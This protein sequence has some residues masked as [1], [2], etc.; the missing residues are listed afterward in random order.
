VSRSIGPA[1]RFSPFHESFLHHAAATPDLVALEFEGQTV[2][3][4]ELAA[5]SGRLATHLRGLGVGP[6]TLVGVAVDRSPELVVGILGI[7]RAGGAWLPLDPSYPAA[8]L[9]YMLDD[10]HVALVVADGVGA[11][12]L[13]GAGVQRVDPG[14]ASDGRADAPP[15]VSLSPDNL[16]YVIYTSGSTGR[17]KGVEVTHG[18]LA[19]LTEALVPYLGASAGK[20]VLQFFS[21]SFDA[22]VSEIVTAL[23]AGATLVLTRAVE[24]GPGFVEFLRSARIT[25]VSLPP[26]L[27]AVLP[28]ADLP[29]LET[30]VCGG[31]TLPEALA[32]RW[33][34]G[35]RLV[36]AY[37]PTEATVCT[38]LADVQPGGGKPPIGRP[39]AGAHVVVLDD[40]L[41]PLPP[42][43]AGQLAIGGL[44]VARGYRGSPALTAERFIP[45]W[46]GPTTGGRLYLTGDSGRLLP[47]G[48]LEFLGRNDDQVKLRGFRIELEEVAAA[49]REHPM[50]RD[51]AAAVRDDSG[52]DRLVAYATGSGLTPG[53]LRQHLADRLPS[54]MVPSAVVVLEEFPLL[55]SGKLDRQ[56]LPAPDRSSAELSVV[57]TAARTPTEREVARLV[58]ELLGVSEIG[59]DDDFFQLGGHSLLAGRLAARAR[60]DL[61]R[62]L[63]IARLYQAPT[64][65]GIA[66]LLDSLPEGRQP[67]PL[68]RTGRSGP[69]PLAFPQERIWF[70]EQLAP[71]NLAYNA[72][73]SVRLR[74]PLDRAVLE[75]TLTEIV[76]RH[77]IL[78]TRFWAVE[79]APVQEPVAP[80]AIDVPFVDVSDLPPAEGEAR[81]EETIRTSM[82]QPFDFGRPPL[83]RW[84][85]IRHAEHDHTLLQVEHH[86]VHDGWSWALF[87][88]ELQAIYGAFHRRQPSPLPELAVQ[89]GDFAV[90]QRNWL[91]DAVLDEYLR[92]WTK[93]LSGASYV[94]NLPT[95]RPRPAMQS[96]VGHALRIDLP[97]E[98]CRQ[99]REFSRSRGVTLYATMLAGFAA[100]LHRYT[101]QTDL[102][103]GCAAA[104][105][106]LAEVE[107]LIGMVV[108]T[109]VLRIDASARPGLDRLARRVHETTT[110]TYD[111]QDVPLDR[112]VNAL[113]LPHDNSRNPLFQ[114]AFSFHDSP[115]PAIEF[116]GLRGTIVE[117]HNG[118]AK[119]DLGIVVIPRAEQQVGVG[120]RDDAAAIT[121][122]WEYATDLFDESTM[123]RMVDHYQNLLGAALCQPEVAIDRLPMLG[124]DE[125]Q[126][127]TQANGVGP[128]AEVSSPP[129]TLPGL[130]EAQVA[131][132][133]EAAAIVFGETVLTYQQLD[134][135]AN[136]LAHA[137][138]ARGVGPEQTVGVA[139]SRSTD[140]VVSILAATKA[141]A[142][143]LPVDPDFP[144][145]RIEALVRDAKPAVLLTTSQIERRLPGLALDT[146]ILDDEATIRLLEG[147]PESPPTDAERITPLHPLHPAYVIY[148]SGSTGTRKGVVVP[149]AGIGS[150]VAA[151]AERFG[152]GAG[153]RVLQFAAPS[154]DA[155][156]AEVAVA[157][158]T[159]ATLVVAPKADIMP[160][161]DLYRL[162]LDKRVT[163][164][165]LPPS[166]LRALGSDVGLPAHLTLVVAGEAC[167]ADLVTQWSRGRR[168][169]NAYGPTET[170][171]CAT[172]SGPLRPGDA[173]PPIGRPIDDSRVYVLD[174]ALQVV[175]VG[176]PGELYVAGAGLARGYLGRPALTAERFVADPYGPPGA[177]MYRTGDVVRWN[178]DHQLEF[179]RRADDQVKIRGFR[180]EPGEI[181]AALATHP[182]V[183][184]VK[185]VV[186]QD[187][188]PDEKSLV[189]YVVSDGAGAVAARDLRDHLVQRLPEYMVPAAIVMLDAF[190]LTHNGKLD[191]DA[192]PAPT[193][194]SAP[195]RPPRT[196]HEQVLADL[197]CELLHLPQVGV[198]DSFFDLGGHS[199][200]AVRL[201][202]RIGA[203]LGVDPTLRT[204]FESPTVA[205]LASRLHVDDPG[206]ALQVMLPLRAGG[207]R[208]ALFC[209]HPG[210]GLGWSYAG[211][212]RHVEAEHP[213]YAVQAR[214]LAG[215]EPLPASVQ[216]MAADYADQ[217]T[218][219]RPE[220]PY[221][222]L[223]WSFGG[224]VAHAVA[225]ELQRRGALVGL[226][227]VLDGYPGRAAARGDAPVPGL[228]EL[229][230]GLFDCDR[231]SLGEPMTYARAREVLSTR[232]SALAGLDEDQLAAVVRVFANNA[233]IARPHTP[234]SF[235]GDLLLFRASTRPDAELP[236]ALLWRPYVGGSIDVHDVAA[237]HNRLMDAQFLAQ[238]GPILAAKL[239]AFPQAPLTY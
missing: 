235:E 81:A 194:A 104:N 115:V 156:V 184:E 187:E 125:R 8:R 123:R 183:A 179:V 190:P 56:S 55:A 34:G 18:G 176:V 211:L 110:R 70:L 36:N 215:T 146:L 24:P 180:I 71:G 189:A 129:A 165:T 148:T 185:V 191:R 150:L 154:F 30:L 112:L 14:S 3:Y 175:P 213:V 33:L 161:P 201:L 224:V 140:L 117:R 29:D 10:S 75:A 51:A 98:L 96:F 133:P 157:L 13:A 149:H 116:E 67:P 41:R 121:L 166:A 1:R 124:W 7:L 231:Q 168:M 222:L 155:S 216:D 19:N 162:L 109:L 214:G 78:R 26:S 9:G 31:E 46:L 218:A 142:A 93:E 101:G 102:L 220:S 106:R 170:T 181:E 171:V 225:A 126:H 203:A 22:S 72:Q 144:L 134:R 199:L 228:G 91:R 238:I 163:H 90:W 12:A 202:A 16:A 40:R 196:P 236:E 182:K 136:R 58:G 82:R 186:R 32:E 52:E 111:W 45:D 100:L 85:L 88:K 172:M 195:A 234:G 147:L 83:V 86:F 138:V 229:L 35:R 173:T 25:H 192:L 39:I 63:P 21:A 114:V 23:G 95:D 48:D 68:V 43:E 49:L 178:H 5:R 206:E 27:L 61:G 38:T 108:N 119:A 227:A 59:V 47:N 118:S 60:S 219:V 130:F 160:G 80:M 54:H 79:G 132:T 145:V 89:F 53:G 207:A 122:I 233:T 169:I 64:V 37:G 164:V 210:T 217:I 141:G 66:A 20:R 94:L 127:L 204:L 44:G 74:G 4:G 105:R 208:P 223:G 128:A 103:V 221:H 230:A 167:P 226:L 73:A 205:G 76:R 137:L 17:P 97:A 159:G 2:T 65:A 152:V 62:E 197:F 42:G 143:Y 209:I 87:L 174:Q 135:Q 107:P 151:Q 28:E 120:P 200:L 212:L 177:R 15:A 50:V 99:L 113:D 237:T 77:E 158:L 188:H 6:E 57:P 232:G 92:F 69:L 139:F 131:R 11:A 153:S 84:T 198:D 193:F 239:A